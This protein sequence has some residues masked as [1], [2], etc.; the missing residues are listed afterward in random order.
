MTTTDVDTS[1]LTAT[2]STSEK[3][4][5]FTVNNPYTGGVAFTVRAAGADQ[6]AEC[7]RAAKAAFQKFIK[8]PAHQRAAWISNAANTATRA[9][10][11]SARPMGARAVLLGCTEIE[12]LV[13]QADVELPV[14]PCTTLHVAAALDRALA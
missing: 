5:I 1:V 13:S 11:A 6:T 7:V 4:Q 2:N 14:I 10:M 3:Y 9:P 8:T 12:L